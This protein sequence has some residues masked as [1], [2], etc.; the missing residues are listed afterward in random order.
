MTSERRMGGV[1]LFE[2]VARARRP[3]ELAVGAVLGR[4]YVETIPGA[5]ARPSPVHGRGLFATTAFARGQRLCELDGQELDPD[6][7]PQ[8]VEALEWNALAPD[9]LLVRALRTSYGLMNHSER[10]NAEVTPDGRAIVARDDIAPGCELTLDYFAQ[11]VP[12]RY[13]AGAEAARLRGQN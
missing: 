8:L 13:R 1:K 5:E 10:P 2:T 4:E 9:R 12:D 3:I 7:Y 6:A 11:P